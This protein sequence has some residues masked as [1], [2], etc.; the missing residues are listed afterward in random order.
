MK[1]I[2]LLLLCMLMCVSVLTVSATE[3]TMGTE[4]GKE[5]PLLSCDTID[6]WKADG[7][8]ALDTEDF[9]E[10]T[11]SVSFTVDAP[12]NGDSTIEF[13]ATFG[14]VNIAGANV[15][16]FDMYI[17]DPTLL[18]AAYITTIDL[19]SSGTPDSNML[20]W[21][22]EVFSSVTKPGWYHI[23]LPFEKALNRSFDD[24]GVKYFRLY[25]F[26][27]NPSEDLTDVVVKFDNFKVN[28]PT[29]RTTMVESCDTAD[30]WTGGHAPYATSPETDT[31]IK[32]QG[33]GSIRYTLNLPGEFHLV[34]N[35]V[36]ATPFN[37]KG[38]THVEMDV[39]ISDV[40]VLTNCGYA[41]QFEVTSSGTCDQQE[42][43]WSLD[44]YVNKNG[45][46]HIRLPIEAAMICVGSNPELSGNPDLSR[47]NY[48]RF[49][50]LNIS[51]AADNQLVFRVD[52]IAFSFPAEEQKEPFYGATLIS[53]ENEGG[54]AGNGDNGGTD[55]GNGENQIPVP[56]PPQQGGTTEDNKD[57][58]KDKDL[59]ARKTEQK[60]KV[61]ILLMVF[62]I[63]GV[64][65]VAVALRRKKREELLLAEGDV[66]SDEVT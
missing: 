52:N 46:S 4:A 65:V 9:T 47:V 16:T 11:A 12:A 54:D 7:D 51:A 27:V 57:K 36:Y 40:N 19:S 48:F 53:P 20:D 25:L 55:N 3:A 30:G 63:I 31:V 28:V 23:E 66:P 39:Y 64:D 43:S 58:D 38:A 24:S 37:V 45:W 34:S 35:K 60:A 50:T 33:Q 22:G 29:Y 10:G 62:A 21:P 2:F 17:S 56:N 5:I 49:H 13:S 42:Y 26:H 15:L 8:I 61:I 44:K 1:R 59:R 6:G 32:K 18:K 41:I 14:A